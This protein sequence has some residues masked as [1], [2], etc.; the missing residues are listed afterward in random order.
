MIR[1]WARLGVLA[2]PAV[3]A[4]GCGRPLAHPCAS[5]VECAVGWSC[6]ADF[7]QP[8]GA[9]AGADVAAAQGR[10]DARLEAGSDVG[11]GSD[12]DGPPPDRGDAGADA[13]ASGSADGPSAEAGPP[14]SP[15]VMFVTSATYVPQFGSLAAADEVC[16]GA[17]QAAGLPGTYRA[18]L[19]TTSTDAISRLQGARGWVRVD[20]APFADT[21]EDIAGGRIFT[22]PLLDENGQEHRGGYAAT[23]VVTGSYADGRLYPGHNCQDWT[24]ADPADVS[25]GEDEGT[26][27]MWGGGIFGGCQYPMR[28]YCFGV[29]RVRSVAPIPV[30]GRRAFVTEGQFQLGGGLAAADALCAS[31]AAAAALPPRFKALLATSTSSAAA[32]FSAPSSTIWVRLDGVPL[33][34]PG[35]DLFDGVPLAAPLNVTSTL[36]YLGRWNVLTGGRT[37]RDTPTVDATCG[38]WTDGSASTTNQALVGYAPFSPL[39]FFVGTPTACSDPGGHLYCLED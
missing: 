14:V 32:R 13:D 17:A 3:A 34:A 18:W 28:I 23:P 1:S 11:R 25:I 33:N 8:D 16:N 27:E 4:A 6:V 39:W 15:N 19:S 36:D 22:P 37:P 29:D 20:G 10:P 12:S 9:D 30:A 35:V 7:C 2:G 5:D 21:P 26:T 24:S 38:D 31:E